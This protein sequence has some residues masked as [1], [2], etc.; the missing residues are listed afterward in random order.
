MAQ[1]GAMNNNRFTSENGK[2]GGPA[3]TR[4][5]RESTKD[6]IVA[7]RVFYHWIIEAAR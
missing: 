4:K 1:V 7:R 6:I 2:A 5:M 3:K